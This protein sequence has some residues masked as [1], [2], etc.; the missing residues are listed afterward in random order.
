MERKKEGVWHAGVDWG[1]GKSASIHF[2]LDETTGEYV[3]SDEKIEELE[4]QVMLREY[5][6]LERHRRATMMID[7]RAGT[8]T[9]ASIAYWRRQQR[10]NA[11]RV[12]Q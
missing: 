9:G 11:I 5:A 8:A 10:L 7:Y 2:T 4:K 12:F 6:Q 3:V 1:V